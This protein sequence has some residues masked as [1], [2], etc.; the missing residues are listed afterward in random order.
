VKI[1]V[2]EFSPILRVEL[3]GEAGRA[4]EVTEIVIK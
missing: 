2:D 1:G 4:N 3:R